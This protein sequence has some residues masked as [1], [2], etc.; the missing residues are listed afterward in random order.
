MNKF[1][2]KEFADVKAFV[3]GFSDEALLVPERNDGAANAAIDLTPWL[4]RNEK[5]NED[6]LHLQVEALR[7][8]RLIQTLLNASNFM[9]LVLNAHRQIIFASD[10]FVKTVMAPNED[11]LIGLRP[12]NAVN[13]IHANEAESGCGGSDACRHCSV[14]RDV[15]A[16][17]N[18]NAPATNEATILYL[19]KE[20]ERSLNVLEHVVPTDIN[21]E[22]CTVVTMMDISD[23]LHRR[24]LEKLFFHDILNKVG[25]LSNYIKLLRKDS[26]QNLAE[27]MSFVDESFT[28]MVEDIRYQK[29]LMEAESGELWAEWMTLVPMDILH[30]IAHLYLFH[31]VAIGKKITVVPND[32][33]PLIRSDYLLFKRVVEN[34]VKNALEATPKGGEV[35]L[36]C[37]LV[38]DI[39]DEAGEAGEMGQ[40]NLTE[41]LR[42]LETRPGGAL[43]IN[44]GGAW[45]AVCV[46]NMSYIPPEVQ[47]HIFKRSFSTKDSNRGLGTYSMKLIGESVLGGSVQFIS[48]EEGGTVFRFYVPVA[49]RE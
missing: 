4:S 3:D 23:T 18:T 35:L 26:P 2:E 29:Q 41:P 33:N 13:C 12:G 5:L 19:E 46:K 20:V 25:A 22:K 49:T 28:T 7:S 42:L 27:D 37:Q 44:K 40:V 17:M 1:N 14:L 34:M 15:L 21:G 38:E 36:S 30:Q 6:T 9:V 48:T 10:M 24:W 45:V 31:D 11:R 32:A 16:A 39:N 47:A 8:N 43:R